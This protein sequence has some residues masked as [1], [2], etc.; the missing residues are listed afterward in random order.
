MRR[1]ILLT[2]AATL[3]A[4]AAAADSARNCSMMWWGKRAARAQVVAYPDFMDVCLDD[5]YKVPAAWNDSS[6]AP[7]GV[8]GKCKDGAWTTA[9]ERQDACVSHGG[10]DTWFRR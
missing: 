7:P 6:R 4:S 1:A 8:T 3:L 2:I 5:F 9:P 10:V